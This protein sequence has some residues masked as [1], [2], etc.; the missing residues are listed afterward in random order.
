MP[1][2]EALN[3]PES[4]RAATGAN[5]APAVR[6]DR[7]AEYGK[8]IHTLERLSEHWTSLI[9]SRHPDMPIVDLDPSLVGLM[10]VAL[11]LHRAAVP[12]LKRDNDSYVDGHNYLTFAEEADMRLP[13]AGSNAFGITPPS[14]SELNRAIQRIKE[15]VVNDASAIS[16]QSMRQYREALIKIIDHPDRNDDPLADVK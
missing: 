11:K 14:D 15:F 5:D 9:R 1:D 4:D 13:S 6:T 3:H 8:P 2:V 10:L 12:N 16:Y 7:E